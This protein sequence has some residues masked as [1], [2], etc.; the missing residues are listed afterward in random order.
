DVTWPGRK[1]TW[2]LVFAV[3]IF[4]IVLGILIALLDYGL[5]NLFR[6]VIL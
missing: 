1:D 2:K 5:E 6:K 4:A 3:F